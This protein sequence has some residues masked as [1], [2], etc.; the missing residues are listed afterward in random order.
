MFIQE[1]VETLTIK[2][3]VVTNK[4]ILSRYIIKI[5]YT[6]Q[7]KMRSRFLVQGKSRLCSFS[8]YAQKMIIA[9]ILFSTNHL[10]G[11]QPFLRII[12]QCKTRQHISYPML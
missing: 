6:R 11:Q 7:E 5:N 10:F 2:K 9:N 1:Q 12:F 8:I 4:E 3:Q